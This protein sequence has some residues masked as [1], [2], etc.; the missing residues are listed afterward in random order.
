[1]I[2]VRRTSTTRCR[3]GC[4]SSPRPLRGRGRWR[5]LGAGHLLDPPSSSLDY[6]T[7]V[8]VYRVTPRSGT[9]ATRRATTASTC[10]T[11]WWS[12]DGEHVHVVDGRPGTARPSPT[13]SRPL[14]PTRRGRA[15]S[16]GPVS[17]SRRGHD[18][19]LGVGLLP[20]W[21]PYH[22]G[23]YSYGRA[24]GPYGAAAWAPGRA[25]TRATS[26]ADGATPGGHAL[27]GGLQR[28]D[29]NAWQAA[30]A[31]PELAHGQRRGRGSGVSLATR[32]RETT[33]MAPRRRG[34][35]GRRRRPGASRR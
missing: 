22:Y 15:G 30:R 19:R 14:R 34:E 11:A 21:G 5:R 26:T 7:Y 9:S 18:R 23:G 1:M 17:G 28:V 2:Q 3:T 35:P 29:G 24:V 25:A 10:P 32:T 6:V 4:G 20:W 8:Y 13:G 12:T 33:P 16:W 27:L 31:C